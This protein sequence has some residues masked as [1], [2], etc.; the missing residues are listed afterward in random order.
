M[1]KSKVIN[2]EMK[3]PQN[4]GEILENSNN[5]VGKSIKGLCP[6]ILVEEIE[7]EA[8]AFEF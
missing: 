7:K 2:N 1:S 4:I 3:C 5:R 6:I 8:N